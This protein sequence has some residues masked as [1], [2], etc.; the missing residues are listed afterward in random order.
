MLAA[1]SA[2]A[3]ASQ[4][5]GVAILLVRPFVQP[6]TARSTA[7]FA[8]C[9]SQRTS[10]MESFRNFCVEGCLFILVE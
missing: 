8:A 2:A 1:V 9:S 5:S 7:Y 3:S 10:R 6:T 4:G